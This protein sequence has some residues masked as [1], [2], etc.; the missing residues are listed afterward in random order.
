MMDGR[1]H[2][3]PAVSVVIPT[4][5]RPMRA[6]EAVLSAFEQS[7]R[8][9]EI[10]LVDDSSSTP[11]A[12]M[13][14]LTPEQ[15]SLV[16]IVRHQDN[17]GANAARITGINQSTGQYIA[18]LDDDDRWHPEKLEKQVARVRSDP[19]VGLVATGQRYESDDGRSLGVDLPTIDGDATKAILT[20]Q[21]LGPFSTLLVGRSAIAEA[22]LPDP[23]L[24]SYQDWEWTIRLSKVTKVASVPEP[25]VHRRIDTADSVGG[26][27]EAKRD[28]TFPRFLY[29]HRDLAA[30]YGP[31]CERQFV[32]A[33]ATGVASTGLSVGQY[34]DAAWFSFAAITADPRCFRPYLYLLASLG[35]RFTYRPMRWIGRLIRRHERTVEATT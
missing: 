13:V 30:S 3:S 1:T 23:E 28:I 29:R 31:A 11:V 8:P 4:Y 21:T 7:H 18:F 32:S 20:G 12:D 16:T 14:D 15:A 6:Q 9:Y 35:G 24:P 34:R 33:L 19:S 25:L 5:N 27:F 10:I 17:K 22:G 2:A 26:D